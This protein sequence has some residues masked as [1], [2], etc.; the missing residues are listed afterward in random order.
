MCTLTWRLEEAG[1]E[2]FFNRDE[3]R[4]RQPELPPALRSAQ[5]YDYIAPEDGNH[6]GTWLAVNC[7]GVTYALLNCYDRNQCYNAAGMRSR[8]LLPQC[9]AALR[10]PQLDSLMDTLG[11]L[12]GFCPFYLIAFVAEADFLYWAWDGSQLNARPLTAADCPLTT[13]SFDGDAV[14]NARQSIYDSLSND[15]DS[16]DLSRYHHSGSSLGGAFGVCMS[17]PDAQT[18]SISRI[19][20]NEHEIH[21]HYQCEPRDDRPRIVS[22]PIIVARIR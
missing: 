20:V 9:M 1:Y 18:M 8:G 3:L 7:Y 12:E 21:Y 4:T 14:V 10:D 5:G 17:R 22:D 11:S 6:Q 16:N 19:V 15:F 13:S 2:L